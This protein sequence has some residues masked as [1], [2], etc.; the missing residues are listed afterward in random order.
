MSLRRPWPLRGVHEWLARA[1]PPGNADLIFVL[2]GRASR[3][4]YGLRLFTEDRAPRIL[5][6]TARFEIRRFANLPLPVPL[7]LLHMVSAVPPRQRHFFVCFERQT[8]QVERI[9]LGKLGT[10]SEIEQLASWLRIRPQIGSVLIVSSGAHLRRVRMCCQALLPKGVLLRFVAV[11]E[12]A[13]GAKS[14]NIRGEVTTDAEILTELPKLMVYRLVL[15]LRTAQTI[16][17]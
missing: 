1:D 6:S 2:A 11:P 16:H 8:S 17:N 3:K 10:F 7:D 15:S 5:L 14:E 4:V 13:S 9:P 12:S